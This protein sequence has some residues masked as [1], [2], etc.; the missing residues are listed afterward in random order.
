MTPY[1]SS[2]AP[3]DD[4]SASSLMSPSSC[5]PPSPADDGRNSLFQCLL[6]LHRKDELYQGARPVATTILTSQFV[7]FYMNAY[8]KGV[9]RGRRGVD[10]RGHDPLTSLLA[11]CLAGVGNV[12]LTNPLWVVNMAIV[13]G[14]TATDSLWAEL[15]TLLGGRGGAGGLRRMYAG[16]PASILLVSNPV[17][18]FFCYE[19]LKRSATGG[20]GDGVRAPAP[21]EAFVLG[22]TAKAIATLVTYPLQLAQTILRLDDNDGD[23]GGGKD[24]Y[25]G[26]VDC[27]ARLFRR[28]G[29]R[30]WYRGMKAK[31]LQSVL[32]SAFMFLTYE[33][34]MA[35]VQAALLGADRV[36][37]RRGHLR[38]RP[39]ALARR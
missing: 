31:M 8:V 1:S 35:A 19:E 13:T 18:Q 9:L 32:T 11:S 30:E 36:R 10:D 24:G 4:E 21:A 7:F 5:S 22:A 29:L 25:K 34:I 27:L 3:R 37:H 26:T 14:E 17:I 6:R 39:P 38:D 20:A 15:R 2:E 12:L 23:G 16:T 28:G 33:Q